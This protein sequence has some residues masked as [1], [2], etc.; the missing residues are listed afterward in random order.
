MSQIQ[1]ASFRTLGRMNHKINGMKN[2]SESRVSRS[3]PRSRNKAMTRSG[4]KNPVFRNQ[5]QTKLF[6]LFSQPNSHPKNLSR[7]TCAPAPWAWKNRWWGRSPSR[8]GMRAR[9]QPIH[10][11]TA[12]SP[13]AFSP[14][15]FSP[16]G[17]KE[18]SLSRYSQFW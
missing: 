7:C 14:R 12:C 16:R 2:K 1:G 9:W 3:L 18:R 13:R 4:I 10:T 15:A 6:S 11:F 17:K 8:N 5:Y